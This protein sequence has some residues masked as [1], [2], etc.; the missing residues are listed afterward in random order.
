MLEEG[1]KEKELL[2]VKYVHWNGGGRSLI[3]LFLSISDQLFVIGSPRCPFQL[4]PEKC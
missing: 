4:Q 2:P 1:Q 3:I